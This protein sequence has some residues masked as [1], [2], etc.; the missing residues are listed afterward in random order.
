MKL[1][2]LHKLDVLGLGSSWYAATN[3]HSKVKMLCT[4]LKEAGVLCAI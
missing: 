1:F 4:S 3:F 2:S